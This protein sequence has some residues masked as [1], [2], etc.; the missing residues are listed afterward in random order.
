MVSDHSEH[1]AANY[2][3]HSGS[4]FQG[5]P[6]MGGWVVYGLGSECR[7]LP[8]F[9]VLESGLVPPGG[10]D[11]FGSGFLPASYQGTLF[12]KGAASGCRPD[13]A[14]GCSRRRS[15]RSSVCCER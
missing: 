15:R 9:V 4:G 11:F 8:G 6:S 13:A 12:R 3:M 14:R 10:L 5:R 7:N 1:T 2:F